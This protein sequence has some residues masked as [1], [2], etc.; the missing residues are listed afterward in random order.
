MEVGTL[1][2]TVAGLLAWLN[3]AAG[4]QVSDEAP[5]IAFVPHPSLERMACA[6][7]CPILGLYPD[8]GVI[9]LDA[10]LQP[11]TNVC[12][13]SILVH[14]LVHYAQDVSGRY[15][16]LEPSLSRQVREAEAL[17]IQNRYLVQHGR[18]I[19]IGR[20][21]NERAAYIGPTC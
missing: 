2:A 5:V 12:A 7:P 4:Y 9:Y 17:A 6:G 14:E 19:L 13:R 10:R 20:Y 18:R 21:V 3:L 11:E 16:H 1:K 15:A 8:E